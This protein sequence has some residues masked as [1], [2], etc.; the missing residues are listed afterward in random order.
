[1]QK[2]NAVVKK[3]GLTHTQ[4]METEHGYI[5]LVQSKGVKSGFDVFMKKVS[6]DREATIGGVKIHFRSAERYPNDNA[7]GVWAWH[8][9]TFDQ[10][11]AKLE[12][13]EALAELKS[14]G[15]K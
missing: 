10:A 3:Y 5:Y 1:M 11:L 12:S 9:M 4:T 6:K 2:L 7:F 13:L 8:Y 15:G 14:S